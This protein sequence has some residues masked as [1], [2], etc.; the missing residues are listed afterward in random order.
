[1]SYA[2]LFSINLG[3]KYFAS[4]LCEGVVFH[5][6]AATLAQSRNTGL[7]FRADIAGILV[8]FEKEKSEVMQMYAQDEDEGLILEFYGCST[9]ASLSDISLFPLLKRDEIINFEKPLATGLQVNL[10]GNDSYQLAVDKFVSSLD[11]TTK[12]SLASY[13]HREANRLGL[14]PIFF[15][16]IQL[17]IS[18][19]VFLFDRE[20]YQQKTVH[21]AA[22]I[23]ANRSHW[24]YR[25]NGQ[26]VSE[27]FMVVDRKSS[28]LFV[29][30]HIENSIS[31]RLT[32]VFRSDAEIELKELTDRHFQLVEKRATGNKVVI[33]RLPMAQAGKGYQEVVENKLIKISEIFVNF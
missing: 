6:T 4:S 24:E 12:N 15:I 14:G 2:A 5:P 3:H 18:D 23:E 28:V 13:S 11:F 32:A 8:L 25:V 10:E 27:D 19:L 33:S 17:S 7:I 22:V 16:R 30:R 9:D 26:G 1:M 31:G 20:K 29:L 21:F